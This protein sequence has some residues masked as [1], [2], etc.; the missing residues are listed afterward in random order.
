MR[1]FLSLKTNCRI[2]LNTLREVFV[3]SL[4]LAIIIVLV[5]G[6][7]APMET[8]SDYVKLAVGYVSVVLG[9]AI[10]L[11]SLNTSILP[12]GKMIGSSLV[13]LKKP[14]FI[15]FFGF[16]FGLLA[17]VA[18]PA[19]VVLARQTNMI[20][21]IVSEPVFIW[22]MGAGIGVMV[23]FA[24]FRMMRDLN[25][26]IVFALLYAVVFLTVF[27]VPEEFVALS[28]DGSGATTGDVSVPFILAL[29]MGV[30]VTMSKTKSNDD[31]F[32]IIGLAS[33]GPI[34][35]LFLYGIILKAANGGRL[36]P[37]GTYDPGA[38]E[39][40]SEILLSNLKGVALALL[41]V[42]LA[43][44]PFQL[45]LIRLPRREF[46]RMMLGAGVVYIGLLIFLSGID[47]GFA[48]AGKYIGEVFLDSARPDWFK[49]LLLPVGFILGAAIT[50]SEPAVAVLAEQLEEIT[51]GHIQKRAI[52][53][54]LSVGIGFAAL[55][56]MVKILTQIN[57]LWFLIPL[58]LIAIL[59]MRYTP[60]LF[61]GLAFDSGGVTGGALTSAFL[62]PLTLG[63]AQAVAA[64]AG[65]R[66]QSVL[67][68][69]FGMIAF[70][71]VTPLI[72]VQMLGIL[73]ESRMK[74][75]QSSAQI[76][77]EE[78]EALESLAALSVTG[79]DSAKP[80]TEPDLS[81]EENQ[82]VK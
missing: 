37:A 18:E 76:T 22:I 29:G 81:E 55:L 42:L 13:Q 33:V 82:N 34:L 3:S 69:G 68:N 65:T 67:T 70:I 51:N 77:G 75:E 71:S 2:F 8:L 59:M 80:R 26:R 38:V 28:F 50:L 24:L 78:L 64:S 4:P 56:S 17:T 44:L 48:F 16:L 6:F 66:A 25:I 52:R 9:Q 47:Y 32:G 46:V 21:P 36:P 73:Y 27:F 58:Y 61:V 20:L 30:S 19:L 43:F 74:K 45:F 49:W 31:T 7:V 12:I 40:I 11:Q 5:C 60:K 79:T 72:A 14:V 53:I 23:A 54:T 15:L 41:P 35:A 39:N 1:A 10:F 63:T 62:T 57:I